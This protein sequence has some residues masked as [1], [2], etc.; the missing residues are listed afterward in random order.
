MMAHYFSLELQGKEAYASLPSLPS[1]PSL[2]FKSS[3]A[4]K[5]TFQP[6]VKR[7][8]TMAALLFLR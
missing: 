8:I 3:M 7:A 2:S 6:R 5:P 1:L 4:I